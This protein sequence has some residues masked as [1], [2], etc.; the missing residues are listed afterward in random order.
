LTRACI[1]SRKGWSRV[2]PVK[3]GND[4]RFTSP[5]TAVV[6]NPTSVAESPRLVRK[7]EDVHMHSS[8]LL[9]GMAMTGLFVL[10]FWAQVGAIATNAVALPKVISYGFAPGPNLPFMPFDPVY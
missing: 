7:I 6:M 2:K 3:P 8:Q 4:N 5:G 1:F 9:L 10:M